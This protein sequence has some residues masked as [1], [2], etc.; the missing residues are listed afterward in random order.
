MDLANCRKNPR[1][2]APSPHPRLPMAVQKRAPLQSRRTTGCALSR[3]GRAQIRHRR[4]R[5]LEI[6]LVK[7]RSGCLGHE[8][9]GA[10][11]ARLSWPE[12]YTQSDHATKAIRPHERR[13]PRYRRP[14]IMSHDDSLWHL[15]CLKQA[16]NIAD[17][18]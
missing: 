13:I 4:L 8:A 14:P 16:N 10:R 5:L 18:M 15:E 12:W 11:C 3:A 6:E 2:E 9:R 1:C 17:Q 7:D